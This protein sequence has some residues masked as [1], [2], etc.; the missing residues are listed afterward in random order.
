MICVLKKANKVNITKLSVVCPLG[1][2]D[3]AATNSNPCGLGEC[4][5]DLKTTTAPADKINP[6][7]KC[8]AVRHCF[9]INKSIVINTLMMVIVFGA[10][11]IVIIVKILLKIGVRM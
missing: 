4:D 10:P 8:A 2:D 3:V 7:K 5:N 1:N 6:A 11:I 9:L